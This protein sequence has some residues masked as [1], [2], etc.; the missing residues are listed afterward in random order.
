M[1]NPAEVRTIRRLHSWGGTSGAH[2]FEMTDG[3]ILTL[4]ETEAAIERIAHKIFQGRERIWD[5]FQ[6]GQLARATG[7]CR[8][9]NPWVHPGLPYHVN[10]SEWTLGW[11]TGVDL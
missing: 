4:T 11:D 8:D 5:S 6:Q 10:I 3:S 1:T 9:A 2:D 7:V